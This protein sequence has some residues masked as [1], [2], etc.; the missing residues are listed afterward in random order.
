[1]T[2]KYELLLDDK[3]E[4]YNENLYRIKAL[5]DIKTR[6]TYG[7]TIVKAGELGGY[8]SEKVKLDH[9]DCS[10]VGEN[11]CILGESEVKGNSKIVS[12]DEAD[13]I[14][15]RNSKIYDSLIESSR[16]IEIDDSTIIR[17]IISD[18]CRFVAIKNS[19]ITNGNIEKSDIIRCCIEN[20]SI[21]E[22]R[23]YGT[24]IINSHITES[25]SSSHDNKL[26]P[27]TIEN[28]SF[29]NIRVSSRAENQTITIKDKKLSGFLITRNFKNIFHSRV[30]G[31]E[32][33]V[34]AFIDEETNEILYNVKCQENI[35]EER[36][37]DRILKHAG[38][39]KDNPHR[40]NYLA[41]I[42]AAKLFLNYKYE[43]DVVN[44]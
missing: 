37:K 7:C 40:I 10:W 9:E 14:I 24:K 27:I 19:K 20:S 26:I 15:I 41:F 31:A 28:C 3:I 2:K 23:M 6:G 34:T 1:M 38:G 44:E 18:N 11:V 35:T 29:E 32:Q 33:G 8:I 25:S 43:G 4:M 12:N 30:N 36:F 17:S 5:I 22:S 16:S 42:E 13:T 39:I 21:C